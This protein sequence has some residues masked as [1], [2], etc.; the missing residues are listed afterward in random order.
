MTSHIVHTGTASVTDG[1]SGVILDHVCR[2][3]SFHRPKGA[4]VFKQVKQK[5]SSA[6]FLKNEDRE[7]SMLF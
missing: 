6:L 4:W 2:W 7:A 5:K 1:D 3:K